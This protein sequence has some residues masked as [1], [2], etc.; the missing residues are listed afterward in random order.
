VI[1]ASD[2]ER[3]PTLPVLTAPL[4]PR[5]FGIINYWQFALISQILKPS[6]NFRSCAGLQSLCQ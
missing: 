3:V 5:K 4:I 1:S 6:L 2:E